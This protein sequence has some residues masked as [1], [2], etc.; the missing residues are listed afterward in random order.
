M[1]T[2]LEFPEVF[3]L[4]IEKKRKLALDL[5][6]DIADSSV[7]ATMIPPAILIELNRRREDLLQHPETGQTWDEVEAELLE[8]YETAHHSADR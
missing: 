1:S 5:W 7:P 3:D 6:Q 2:R 8:K 4:P